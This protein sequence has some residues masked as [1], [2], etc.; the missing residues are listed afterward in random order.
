MYRFWEVLGVVRYPA[1]CACASRS[2]M[3]C[4][5]TTWRLG[6]MSEKGVAFQTDEKAEVNMVTIEIESQFVS[7]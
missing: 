6:Y 5:R 2:G 7:T 3:V 1:V 4:P